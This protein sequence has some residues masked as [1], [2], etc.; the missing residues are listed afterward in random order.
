M[1]VELLKVMLD[2][3]VAAMWQIGNLS[4][5]PDKKSPGQ[6]PPG[7]KSPDN[8]P[9]RIIEEIIANYAVDANLFRLGSTNPKKNPA[10]FFFGFYTGGLL[11][12]GFCQSGFC[13]GG[14]WPGGFWPRTGK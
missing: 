12:Q 13:P 8:K 4:K 6:K 10:P 2:Q 14:F 3:E 1:A 5:Y 11:S 9:P 7:Q